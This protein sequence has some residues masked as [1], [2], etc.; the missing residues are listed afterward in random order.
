[1]MQFFICCVDV[2]VC[3]LYYE[4]MVMWFVV[5]DLMFDVVIDV[6]VCVIGVGFVGLLM[7]FDCCVCGLLVVVIDVQWFGWGVLGCNGGQVIIGFVKDEV[8]EQQFG[9]DGVCVVWLL[10]FDGVVLIVECIVCYGIDCDFMCGYLMVVMKLCCIDD[11]CVWMNVVMLCWGYLLFVWFD[12]GEIQVCIVLMCYLV[13][14]YDLLLGYL[15]LFK[16]CFGFVDVVCC[17]GVVLYV[18]MLVFDVVCGVWF[19]VCMLLGEVCCCFVVLCCN[20][21]FGGV[22]LV[23]IVVC[24]VLIVLYIIV[25]ELFGWVCVDVLIV[26]CEVVCDNNFFFDYFWLLVDYWMLFGGWVNLVGVLFVVFVEVIW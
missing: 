24:I 8:I 26:W 22:L 12:I 3:D 17:E 14:V 6:D 1:M 4:V 21:G 20:V 13:G 2:F 16:Y 19:V 18:Y 10:L 7:V 9:V 15:Y 25:I 11:L 5:D 23:V